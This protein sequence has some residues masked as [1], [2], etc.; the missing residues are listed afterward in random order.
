MIRICQ[1]GSI[2]K[3]NSAAYPGLVAIIDT[4]QNPHESH[5]LTGIFEMMFVADKVSEV[6]VDLAGVESVSAFLRGPDA[7]SKAFSRKEIDFR[8]FGRL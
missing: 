2:V 7:S 8:L 4:S 3:N 1:K 5:D 6:V